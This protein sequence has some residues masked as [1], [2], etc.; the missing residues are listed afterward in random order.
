MNILISNDDGYSAGLKILLNSS[1]KLGNAYAVIPNKQQSGVSKAIT[2]HK[3]LRLIK[4]EKY[5]FEINGTPA[6]CVA[7]S[8]FSNEFKNPDLVLS[9]IN[10]GDNTSLHSIFTS[11]TLAACV[12]ATLFNIPSIGFSVYREK[13][14]WRERVKNWGNEKIIDFHILNIAKK[15][16]PLFSKNVFFSVNFPENLKLKSKIVISEPQRNRFDVKIERR[17]DPDGRKY[18]WV[19]GPQSKKIKKKDYYSVSSGKIV[20]TPININLF[21]YSKSDELKKVF[22]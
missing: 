20:I 9:G 13:H 3:P 12:E 16:K 1:K 18:F 8:R 10:W 19:S 14:K 11:G 4:R 6:D 22:G 2:L 17:I 15:L 5:I 21:D 7:F